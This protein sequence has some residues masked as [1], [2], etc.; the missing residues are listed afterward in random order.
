MVSKN[1]IEVAGY[2]N[3]SNQILEIVIPIPNDETLPGGGIQF[4]ASFGG[5]YSNLADTINIDQSDLGMGKIVS[6]SETDF[7]SIAEFT[8]NGNAT[9]QAVLW[10]KAGNSTIGTASTST[11]HI[12]QTLPILGT[13]AQ[14]TN[15]AIAD[16][17]AKV[18]DTDT[19]TVSSTEGLD[20]LQVQIFSQDAVHSGA[21]RDWT[22]TY[23]F[24]ETDNDVWFHSILYLAILQEIWELMFLPQRMAV[25]SDLMEQNPCSHLFL[26]HQPIV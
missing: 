4:Q 20:T 8:E 25:Q 26:F 13:V 2:W 12:D 7:E 3:A 19:L 22:F 15:N 11:I 6:I 24:Q 21:N 1:G 18:G 5:S 9:F 10:D 16:S 23:S 17:L 14:S